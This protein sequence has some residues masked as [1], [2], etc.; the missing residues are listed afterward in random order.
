MH[1]PVDPTLAMEMNRTVA[2]Q[3][4]REGARRMTVSRAVL[5]QV[6][7]RIENSA[8]VAFPMGGLRRIPHPTISRMLRLV[9]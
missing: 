4:C 2:L 3:R 1:A 7:H 8:L 6:Q 5:D 9:W